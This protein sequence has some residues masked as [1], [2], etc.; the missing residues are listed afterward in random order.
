MDVFPWSTWPVIVTIGC[1]IFVM[2]IGV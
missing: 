2:Y 1:R